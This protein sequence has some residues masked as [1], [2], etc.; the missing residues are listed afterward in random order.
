MTLAL[1]SLMIKRVDR[2]NIHD[3]ARMGDGRHAHVA[4]IRIGKV[5]AMHDDWL[6]DDDMLAFNDVEPFIPHHQRKQSTAA[7]TTEQ[8]SL[9]ASQNPSPQELT[10]YW[11]RRSIA[12]EPVPARP[13]KPEPVPCCTGAMHASLRHQGRRVLCL[14]C[15]TIYW[16]GR[17]AGRMG[18]NLKSGQYR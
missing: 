15:R 3:D 7:A 2:A 5:I 11:S 17:P 18:M 1:I 14:S 4:S 16:H 12:D 10:P 9:I 13:R 8:M 6:R